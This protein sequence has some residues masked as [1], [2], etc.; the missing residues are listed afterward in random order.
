MTE[1]WSTVYLHRFSV[2]TG[3]WYVI[4][5]A[6]VTMPG[7]DEPFRIYPWFFDFTHQLLNL[8]PIPGLTDRK[9]Q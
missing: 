1:F 6:I 9:P 8:K 5:A 3:V 7:K 4:S 2:A